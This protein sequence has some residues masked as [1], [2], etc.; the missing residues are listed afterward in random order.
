MIWL[1]INALI[2]LR[3]KHLTNQLQKGGC[4]DSRLIILL[5][6][7]FCIACGGSF[8][9]TL[10]YGLKFFRDDD[11][12]SVLIACDILVG[13]FFL[14]TLSNA[15][16]E[17]RPGGSISQDYLLTFPVDLRG[18]F[19][20][21]L[22]SSSI[23]LR[24]MWFLS[25]TLGVGIAFVAIKGIGGWP[26]FILAVSFLWMVESGGAAMRELFESF[27][28][29][30]RRIQLYVFMI[31]TLFMMAAFGPYLII[32]QTSLQQSKVVNSEFRK[33]TARLSRLYHKRE[34]TFEDFKSY[35]Q[36]N[37]EKFDRYFEERNK[38]S[39]IS[40]VYGSLLSANALIPLGWFSY[41]IVMLQ[42]NN[43]PMVFLCTAG[44]MGVGCVFLVFAYK[45]SQL[46]FEKQ[47][48]FR[49][50]YSH[51]KL[52]CDIPRRFNWIRLPCTTNSTLAVA[53]FSFFIMLRASKTYQILASLIIPL[54]IIIGV[55]STHFLDEFAQSIAP[56]ALICCSALTLFIT[57]N[58]A[59]SLFQFDKSEFPRFAQSPMPRD[60][61]LIGKNLSLA[62]FF[63]VVGCLLL[64]LVCVKFRLDYIDCLGSLIQL[65]SLWVT[66]CL[67]GN[68]FFIR[69]PAASNKRSAKSGLTH[70]VFHRL[71]NASTLIAVVPG[72]ISLLIQMRY[73]SL[74]G[75]PIYFFVEMAQGVISLLVYD[76]IV[77][78]QGARLQ[79][80]EVELLEAYDLQ[81]DFIVIA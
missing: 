6:I 63:V 75:F 58:W 54:G 17:S 21:R 62:P 71:L 69:F 34:I 52:S 38:A 65:L 4:L 19:L 77:R 25:V 78:K 72:A 15:F 32:R 27:S 33:E 35:S 61:V 47:L 30:N 55:G 51:M 11:R 45:F 74:S 26:F 43:P 79:I 23:S 14:T 42:C 53:Y 29:S 39:K 13:I 48:L 31:I 76:Y 57:N 70:L 41:G 10:G 7:G 5:F 9:F 50:P 37:R 16:V 36:M 67:I 73:E 22:L 68:C 60:Q 18:A 12:V 80:C 1:Q 20:I 59:L 28:R 64:G 56:V 8:A 40:N 2:G 44:M 49:L 24:L 81:R 3:V 46:I 66:A